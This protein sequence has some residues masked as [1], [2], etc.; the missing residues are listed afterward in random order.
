VIDKVPVERHDL[1]QVRL[2]SLLKANDL[3]DLDLVET[4]NENE[5]IKYTSYLASLDNR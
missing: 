5:I 1:F 2:G 3:H 4:L